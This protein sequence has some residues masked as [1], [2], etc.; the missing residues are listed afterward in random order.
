ME[1]IKANK[2]KVIII[3]I[4]VITLIA[5]ICIIVNYCDHE[6]EAATCTNP[7]VCKKC[8][9]TKG[10]ALGHRTTKATCVE[11]SRYKRCKKVIGVPADHEYGEYKVVKE[12][13]FE[14]DGEKERT[15]SV[16]GYVEHEKIEKKDKKA[17]LEN[18]LNNGIMSNVKSFKSL[19][20]QNG[21]ALKIITCSYT[22]ADYSQTDPN[23]TQTGN[24]SWKYYSDDEKTYDWLINE[25]NAL[26]KESMELDRK[27]GTGTEEVDY[28]TQQ[29]SPDKSIVVLQI[30]DIDINNNVVVIYVNNDYSSLVKFYEKEG[31]NARPG[32]I[33]PAF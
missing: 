15:C 30:K 3:T 14:E 5:S 23:K 17:Y 22:D 7:K 10:E 11:A 2:D 19:C 21:L 9:K 18:I 6:W 13:T 24:F 12:A 1:F 27:Y 25:Y 26:I 16:C 20:D 33:S 8:E 29:Y 31:A 4:I 28:N 32:Y